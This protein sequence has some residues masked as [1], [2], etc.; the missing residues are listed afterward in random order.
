MP[1]SFSNAAFLDQLGP[2]TQ[3]AI[4]ETFIGPAP[5]AL[6]HYTKPEIAQKI[7]T[8]REI[9]ATC[10]TAQNDPTE[11]TNGINLIERTAIQ[12]LDKENNLFFRRVLVELPEYMRIRKKWIFITCFCGIEQSKLHV[13]SFGASCFRFDIPQGW[14]PQFECRDRT[15]NA[16]YSPVLYSER[17][18]LQSIRRFLEELRLVVLRNLQGTPEHDRAGW[19]H[20]SVTRDAANCLLLLAACFKRQKYEWEREWRLL[21][22]PNLAPGTSAPSMSDDAFAIVIESQPV[23]HIRLRRKPP[24]TGVFQNWILRQAPAP[25]DGIVD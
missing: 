9:W 2:L 13:S 22:M 25:F 14:R 15:A 18:Q 3:R 23:R 19:L 24:A 11:L 20:Q 10:L 21:F 4:R 6:Y 12:F 17:E 1:L 7:I 8:S 5:K 16:W